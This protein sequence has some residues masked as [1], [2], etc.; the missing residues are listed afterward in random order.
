MLSVREIFRHSSRL[1]ASGIAGG[2]LNAGVQILVARRLGPEGLGVVGL[3]QLFVLYAGL[4]RPGILASGYREILDASG[5]GDEAEA[6]RIEGVALFGEAA[7]ILA[8]V[9]ALA[10]GALCRPAGSLT[11]AALAV[12]AVTFLVNSL[13]QCADTVQW[14]YR[15]FEL[16][17][18]VNSLLKLGQPLLVLAGLLTLGL[19]GVL[20]APVVASAAALAAYLLTPGGLHHAYAWDGPTL[21]RLLRTGLPLALYGLAYWAMRSAD[22]AMSSR[23]L[24]L[25]ALGHFTFAMLFINQACQWISDFLNVLQADLFAK[26]G[27]AGRVRPL[28]YSLKRIQLLILLLTGGAAAVG[29]LVCGPAVR[30]LVP[31]FADAVPAFETMLLLLPAI[32][33]P[34]L[35]TTVLLSK[36]V[37]RPLSMAA[38][39]GASLLFNVA[40]AG[41]LVGRGWDLNG[42]AWASVLGQT[43]AATGAAALL[44]PHLFEGA[45]A[46]ES[47]RFYGATALL[48]GL[49]LA[50]HF[51]L[52]ATGPLAGAAAAGALWA[53]AA[54]T[55]T[56]VWP[57]ARIAA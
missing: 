33:A 5:R 48:A 37:D 51:L 36:V 27:T 20:A 13:F 31:N 46:G 50:V 29:Q 25:T 55:L 35:P 54:W 43:A 15:R 3:V 53:A 45:D 6:R 38:V 18:R 34:L 14:A 57:N 2:A 28:S 49:A 24:S 30:L 8:I 21:R 1:S 52:R 19:R 10:V 40:V 9:S 17:A 7:A 41:A 39:Q 32:A 47:L 22:R 16:A 4:V 11:R 26:L 23:L 42:V 44:H 56:R 12:A